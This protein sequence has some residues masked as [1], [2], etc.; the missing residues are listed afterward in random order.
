M[1]HMPQLTKHAALRSQ[2]RG[3]DEAIIAAAIHFGERHHPGGGHK[4]FFLGRKAVAKARSMWNTNLS[5]YQNVA[6]IVSAD[7]RIV[8]VQHCP[9]PKKSWRGRH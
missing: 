9:A 8:T 2:Q 7:D 6:V 4:A 1:F 5:D 3:I